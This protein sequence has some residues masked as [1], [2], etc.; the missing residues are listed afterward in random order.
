MSRERVPAAACVDG[1]ANVE[2]ILPG[3]EVFHF[4]ARIEAKGWR[5]APGGQWCPRHSGKWAE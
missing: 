5:V 4:R 2:Y 3:E 1:C